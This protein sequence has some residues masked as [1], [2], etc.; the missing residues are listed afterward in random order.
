[1]QSRHR[2]E[3]TPWR[4]RWVDVFDLL[5]FCHESSHEESPEVVA[6]PGPTRQGVGPG[7]LRD[8]VSRLLLLARLPEL[9]DYQARL[10][11]QAKSL[12]ASLSK[13]SLTN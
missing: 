6:E 10:S 13:G 3:R 9:A 2:V 11:R 5:V 7:K 1:M 12:Q 4:R 8:P